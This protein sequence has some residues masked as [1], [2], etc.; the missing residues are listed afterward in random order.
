MALRSFLT[1]HQPKI[2]HSLIGMAG[3]LIVYF[4]VEP[5]WESIVVDNL[6]QGAMFYFFIPQMV[7][8]GII[9]WGIPI[10]LFV[11]LSPWSTTG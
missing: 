6:S 9:F 2:T 3:C 11:K 5:L 10:C 8:L 1:Q 7:F 4:I